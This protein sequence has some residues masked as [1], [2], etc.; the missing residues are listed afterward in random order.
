VIND[1]KKFI[2]VRYLTAAK[3]AQN[4]FDSEAQRRFFDKSC[5]AA[6]SARSVKSFS[7]GPGSL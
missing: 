1:L 7:S 5:E 2:M 3:R 6:Q 4:F